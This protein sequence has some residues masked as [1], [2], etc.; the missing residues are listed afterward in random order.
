MSLCRGTQPTY[1]P[2]Q[3]IRSTLLDCTLLSYSQNITAGREVVFQVL[4][5]L[6][7]SW[8]DCAAVQGRGAAARRGGLEVQ[9]LPPPPARLHPDQGQ[10]GD[11]QHTGQL[12]CHSYPPLCSHC[13]VKNITALD[14]RCPTP[15]R[16]FATRPATP[17]TRPRRR[18]PS[19]C[20]STQVS[21]SSIAVQYCVRAARLG[22]ICQAEL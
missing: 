14:S 20:W 21:C 7:Q 10:A 5:S 12:N 16:M 4:T 6:L 1:L 17:P 8:T 19:S 2:H 15:G 13:F 3:V 22:H 9:Q 18:S 11:A